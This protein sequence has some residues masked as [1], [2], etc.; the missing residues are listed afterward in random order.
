MAA[1]PRPRSPDVQVYRPQLTSVLSIAHRATGV[2]LSLGAVLLI[3]WLATVAAG[4]NAALHAFFGSWG[5]ILLL[6]LWTFTLFY[7]LCNGIRH[8]GW[9]LNYGFELRTIYRTGWL[10]VT[11]S[12][13]LTALTWAVAFAFMN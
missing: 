5:G 2:W 3:A 12:V 1:R 11:A 9:D 6:V 4:A 13:C 7:H 8:L 10:V